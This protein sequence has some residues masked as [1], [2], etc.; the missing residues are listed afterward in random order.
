M[1]ERP[2]LFSTAMVK[3]ILESRKTQTR[4]V[5]KNPYKY[6]LNPD[7]SKSMDSFAI[8]GIEKLINNCP[9]G[10]PGDRLWV[11][12]TWQETIFLH[13]S[14]E[15]YGYIY[16]ASENGE[17]WESNDENWKWKPSIFMPYEAARILLEITDIRVERVQDISENDAISEGI[18][19]VS[20]FE[21]LGNFY[22]NYGKEDI[23]TAL[24]PTN[25]FRTLWNSINAKRGYGW[26]VN[27]WV[28]VV[29]FK[30]L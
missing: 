22:A 5:I 14:D 7:F 8:G 1:K 23:G 26:D 16:K 6:E 25:S 15:N 20:E 30:K 24:H 4:R 21:L 18:E 27:P 28:W 3:A 9:Y 11:R 19:M 17:A 2:I 10:K 29:E 12:E 13:P